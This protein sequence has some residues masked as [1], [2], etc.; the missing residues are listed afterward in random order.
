MALDDEARHALKVAQEAHALRLHNLEAMSATTYNNISSGKSSSNYNNNH[1]AA[2]TQSPVI[3]TQMTNSGVSTANTAPIALTSTNPDLSRRSSSISASSVTTTPIQ[4]QAKVEIAKPQQHYDNDNND[5]DNNNDNNNENHHDNDEDDDEEDLDEDEINETETNIF[6]PYKIQTKAYEV[7]RNLVNAGKVLIPLPEKSKK[8]YTPIEI[9]PGCVS[10]LNKNWEAVDEQTFILFENGFENPDLYPLLDNYSIKLMEESVNNIFLFDA[11]LTSTTEFLKSTLK[12]KRDIDNLNNS[13]NRNM[14]LVSGFIKGLKINYPKKIDLSSVDQFYEI[15]NVSLAKFQT[16]QA[17]IPQTFYGDIAEHVD[18]TNDFFNFAMYYV[19]SA[20]MMFHNE[21]CLSICKDN[22]AF[23]DAKI[24]NSN[25]HM[26][27]TYYVQGI[28]Y[29]H[30]SSYNTVFLNELLTQLKAIK[31]IVIEQLNKESAKRFYEI[32]TFLFSLTQY[33]NKLRADG[34]IQTNRLQIMFYILKKWMLVAPEEFLGGNNTSSF[35]EYLFHLYCHCITVSL[36]S[37][38]PEIKFFY[39]YGFNTKY[40]YRNYDK[41]V[42]YFKENS[43]YISDVH[44]PLVNY[45]ILL[46]DFFRKRF[47][48]ISGY[49]RNISRLP[50]KIL[51]DKSNKEIMRNLI[52]EVQLESFNGLTEIPQESFPSVDT[53]SNFYNKET[54]S[55]TIPSLVI[56]DSFNNFDKAHLKRSGLLEKALQDGLYEIDLELLKLIGLAPF[57]HFV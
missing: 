49:L 56:T 13:L 46:V 36:N 8:K 20:F 5:N 10:R 51:L 29:Y 48:L 7:L 47:E 18:L 45:G 21:E 32:E 37:I 40:G 35:E 11:F 3:N 54:N 30:T 31:P 43:K 55:I 2:V 26:F 4:Q 34:S 9:Q 50:A 19:N 41:I 28:K 25:I 12:D 44:L 42:Q 1:S 24:L 22:K 14:K 38:F 57:K 52:K 6:I 23:N 33:F 16:F 27:I 17:L 53:S 39:L 15:I